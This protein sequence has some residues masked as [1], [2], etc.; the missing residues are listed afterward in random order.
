MVS[1]P[2]SEGQ[3]TPPLITAGGTYAIQVRILYSL[4]RV[5]EYTA[6]S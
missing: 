5:F 6:S 4:P 2:A 1:T 3:Q